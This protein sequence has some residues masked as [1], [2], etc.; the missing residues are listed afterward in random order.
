MCIRDRYNIEGI[1]QMQVKPQIGLTFANALRS[2]L[3]QDPDVLMIGEMRDRETAEIAV[4]AALTGH[5]VLSTLHTNDAVSSI[6][7]LLDMGVED[8][9]IT[10][11]LVAVV[12]QR[13][14]R[15]ICDRCR[16]R[17]AAPQELVRRWRLDERFPGAELTL[18]QGRGCSHCDG[19][20]Y[21]GRTALAE[22]LRLDDDIRGL[23][24]RRAAGGEMLA[25][26]QAAGMQ[27]MLDMGL[28][29]VLAG[30]TT[31]EEVLRVT[32]ERRHGK[33]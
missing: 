1:N 5:L 23:I 17:A 27:T 20:G 3:R 4:Q 26:A 11:S 6:T 32:R 12:A 19:T 15:R 29:R 16:S 7:R 14:V 2:F 31:L 9:L 18:S 21:K 24:Y 13:L 10:S 8:Y 25:A 33:L 28:Q 30:E 22:V